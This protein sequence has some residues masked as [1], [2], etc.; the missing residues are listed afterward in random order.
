M[1]ILYEIINYIVNNDNNDNTFSEDDFVYPDEKFNLYNENYK[2][3]IWDVDQE[4]VSFTNKRLM[5]SYTIELDIWQNKDSTDYS[6]GILE[7]LLPILDPN[8]FDLTFND[9]Q[10]ELTDLQVININDE[11]YTGKGLLLEITAV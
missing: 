8:E 7:R 6:S 5:K 2:I 11:N 9:V 1:N 4:F 10:F 3:R